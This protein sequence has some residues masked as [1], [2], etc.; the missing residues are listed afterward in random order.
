MR[1][2]PPPP[3]RQAQPGPTLSSVVVVN[4]SCA[5]ILYSGIGGL[6]LV[7]AELYLPASAFGLVA[8]SPLPVTFAPGACALPVIPDAQPG[9]P[10][11]GGQVALVDV[12]F[13]FFDDGGSAASAAVVGAAAVTMERVYVTGAPS[14]VVFASSSTSARLSCGAPACGMAVASAAHGGDPLPPVKRDIGS[15]VLSDPLYA[16][17]LP[18]PVN[19]TSNATAFAPGVPVPQPP[20]VAALH[21]YAARAFPTWQ[22]LADGAQCAWD[23]GVVGDGWADDAAGLQRALSAAAAA[24]AGSPGR[25][26]FLPRSAYRLAS[27][28]LLLSQVRRVAAG[29]GAPLPVTHRGCAAECRAPS[30]LGSVARCP[31]SLPTPLGCRVCRSTTLRSPL[32]SSWRSRSVRSR[33][34]RGFEPP[35]DLRV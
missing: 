27:A 34:A 25:A 33:G 11:L 12:S 16:A 20:S 17:S 5:G 30:S 3:L 21:S 9:S 14:G 15:F 28:G 2:T 35:A 4:A 23:F 24:P 29:S 22:W 13:A 10:G 18:A 7:G 8:G 32:R 1:C 19:D 6:A 31:C 26:V